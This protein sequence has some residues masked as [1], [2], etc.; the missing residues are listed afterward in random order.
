MTIGMEGGEEL[1]MELGNAHGIP[2]VLMVSFA[3]QGHLNPLLR[4]A[5][6]IAAKGLLVTLCSTHD[7]RHRMVNSDSGAAASDLGAPKPVGRGFIRFEF[8]SDGLPVDDVRRKDL[9]VLMPAVRVTGQR[10]VADII[11]RHAEA[12]RPVS[13]VINNPF[14]PWALDVAAEMGI[15]GGVL[16]VQSAAVFATYYYYHHGL[17]K[18][19]TEENPDVAA[20]RLPGLPLLKQE[21]L[22]TF[23][24]PTSEYKPLREVI[25]EQFRNINK[26]AWVFAN[27]FH[28]LEREAIEAISDRIPIIPVGPLVEPPEEKS[29]P[30][31][32]RGDL[33]KA[34]DCMEWLD[35]Q[36]PHSVVYVS[37]GSILVLSKEEMEEMAWGLCDSHRPFLWVV[38]GDMRSLLPEGFL[39]AV[40]EWSPQEEVLAH[41]AVACFVTHCGWNSTL[42][43]LTAGVP[44]ITYPQFGDQVPDSKFL[45]EVFGVG[46]RLAAPATR[47]QMKRCVEAVSTKQRGEEIRKRA[48]EWK[49]AAT[50]AVAEDGSSDRHIQAFVDE[51]TNKRSLANEITTVV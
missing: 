1:S 28:E 36:E 5:K 32:I 23:L 2:H 43:A 30:A 45:V 49:K 7:I 38:R 46:V 51:I 24:L 8:F 14:V 20:V 41:P 39:D 33:F 25:L 47:E 44:M 31:G 12:G 9:D 29:S 26:A 42:E 27:T 6:R 35:A 37:V 4:L 17:G 22:P 34:E 40:I 3:G 15:P 48:A 10:A 21:E 19:P 11:R 18:F 50:A 13:C 16:W